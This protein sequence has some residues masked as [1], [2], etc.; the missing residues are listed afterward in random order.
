M[1]G[2]RNPDVSRSQKNFKVLTLLLTTDV[3]SNSQNWQ[4]DIIKKTTISLLIFASF[5]LCGKAQV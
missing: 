1:H 2:A 4:Y 3:Q 5:A